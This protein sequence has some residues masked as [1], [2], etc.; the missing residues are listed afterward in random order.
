MAAG[1]ASMEDLFEREQDTIAKVGDMRSETE[2]LCTRLESELGSNPQIFWHN[3]MQH[4]MHVKM[5]APKQLRKLI[6]QN[7]PE[8]AKNLTVDGSVTIT[9]DDGRICMRPSELT[10]YSRFVESANSDSVNRVA[11]YNAHGINYDSLHAIYCESP[12]SLLDTAAP[13]LQKNRP[14]PG[15]PDEAACRGRMER[16]FERHV[17]FI[18]QIN[19]AVLQAFPEH[20]SEL[21]KQMRLPSREDCRNFIDRFVAAEDDMVKASIEHMRQKRRSK[22]PFT[23]PADEHVA[24]AFRDNFVDDEVLHEIRSALK[25]TTGLYLNRAQRGGAFVTDEFLE[26][27][28]RNMLP[29]QSVGAVPADKRKPAGLCTEDR[30]YVYELVMHQKRIAPDSRVIDVVLEAIRKSDLSFTMKHCECVSAKILDAVGSSTGIMSDMTDE[31]CAVISREISRFLVARLGES[32]VDDIKNTY[33]ATKMQVKGNHAAFTL[34]TNNPAYSYKLALIKDGDTFE[35]P[36]SVFTRACAVLAP[37]K[38]F[39]QCMINDGEEVATKDKC[40]R[41][42]CKISPLAWHLMPVSSD[43]DIQYV[44]LPSCDDSGRV[45][46]LGVGIAPPRI[47]EENK[48]FMLACAQY[49]ENFRRH[50]NSDDLEGVP[51]VVATGLHHSRVFSDKECLLREFKDLDAALTPNEYDSDDVKEVIKSL[52]SSVETD[53]NLIMRSCPHQIVLLKYLAE[54]S[55]ARFIKLMNSWRNIVNGSFSKERDE[56]IRVQHRV[57]NAVYERNPE[58]MRDTIEHIIFNLGTRPFDLADELKLINKHRMSFHTSHD[59]N[60]LVDQMEER[61]SRKKRRE[62]RG[63]LH[64]VFMRQQQQQH[65]RP[66][67]KP[68]GQRRAGE[69]FVKVGNNKRRTQGFC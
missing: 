64:S 31:Q 12:G 17:N 56:R 47:R 3:P 54:Q 1:Y 53:R 37:S 32:H 11:G 41:D 68:N 40:V 51:Y 61:S 18:A 19:N 45:V 8:L 25:D 20:A 62:I 21:K 63:T 27:I 49:Y 46:I 4:S 44:S 13:L 65:A 34:Y 15:T 43:P 23:D 36:Y 28:N 57:M 58:L 2:A 16:G 39:V 30:R 22:T 7:N 52:R 24:D 67:G 26:Q 55:P 14:G 50:A 35:V 38:S 59:L 60:S 48:K 69:K 66:K 5:P 33:P 42:A 6:M 10:F 9:I 29:L